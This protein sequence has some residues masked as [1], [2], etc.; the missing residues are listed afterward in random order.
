MEHHHRLDRAEATDINRL[1]YRQHRQD[2]IIKDRQD[3]ARDHRADLQDQPSHLHQLDQQHLLACR[4]QRSYRFCLYSSAY[5]RQSIQGDPS[6][7]FL[8]AR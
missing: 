8:P 5:R 3:L 2:R 1:D 6:Y 4:H 7:R